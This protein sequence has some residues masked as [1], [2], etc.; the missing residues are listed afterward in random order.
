M[1][2]SISNCPSNSKLNN[3][4][5]IRHFQLSSPFNAKQRTETPSISIEIPQT[6]ASHN[7]VD[8][9]IEAECRVI[10]A[11]VTREMEAERRE[12]FLRLRTFETELRR[13]REEREEEEKD[14]KR[15]DNRIKCIQEE[16]RGNWRRSHEEMESIMEEEEEET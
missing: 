2:R 16:W 1:V 3:S 5:A 13:M 11:Q 7:P 15:R 9:E 6:L 4:I 12:V 14:K 8:E 10:E